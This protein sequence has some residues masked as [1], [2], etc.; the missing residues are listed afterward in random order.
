VFTL[1]AGISAG[2]FH[3][4]WICMVLLFPKKTF[5]NVFFLMDMNW[6]HLNFGLLQVQRVWPPCNKNTIRNTGSALCKGS[7]HSGI[8]NVINAEFSLTKS[9]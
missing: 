8:Y 7:Q 3:N 4:W 1:S 5:Y 6:G 9:E 2:L